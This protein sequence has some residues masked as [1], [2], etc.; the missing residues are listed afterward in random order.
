MLGKAAAV[1]ALG[2]V[3]LFSECSRRE[4]SAI[5]AAG[6]ETD[7]PSGTELTHEGSR[8]RDFLVLL[9]GQVDVL[10]HGEKIAE[11]H[12]GDFFGEISLVAHGARTATVVTTSPA[13]AF[14]LNDRTFRALLGRM[15]DL[16]AKVFKALAERLP[17]DGR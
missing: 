6:S 16:Q 8:G 11:R 1:E 4:L 5:A 15:P 9:E 14:V 17:R 2:N 3:P 12:T 13:R 10:R 7:Y